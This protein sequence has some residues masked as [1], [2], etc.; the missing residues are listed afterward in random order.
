MEAIKKKVKI[1]PLD[2]IN[3]CIDVE[4]LIDTGSTT[5]AVDGD[6]G[7]ELISHDATFIPRAKTAETAIKGE[8]IQVRGF[9]PVDVII[10]GKRITSEEPMFLRVVD[11]LSEQGIFGQSD[12]EKYDITID[13]VTGELHI[14]EHPRKVRI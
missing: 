14:P 2:K 12:L 6:T 4:M 8:K 9:I 1:C 3:D 13:P 5:S 7:I 10:D 11:D